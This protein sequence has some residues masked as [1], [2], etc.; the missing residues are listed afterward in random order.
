M[1]K[2]KIFGNIHNRAEYT[3]DILDNLTPADVKVLIKSCEEMRVAADF[4]RIFP[5][6]TTHRYQVFMDEVTYYDKLLDSFMTYCQDKSFMEGVQLVRNMTFFHF[7]DGFVSGR[8]NPLEV[9][10]RRRPRPEAPPTV[11]ADRR[12]ICGVSEVKE[13]LLKLPQLTRRSAVAEEAFGRA[14]KRDSILD[15]G[16]LSRILP[17][18]PSRNYPRLD[19][20]TDAE[21]RHRAAESRVATQP[22]LRMSQRLKV[23]LYGDFVLQALDANLLESIGK[24]VGNAK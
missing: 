23:L 10:R 6:A 5:T 4:T 1:D 13:R 17:R 22:L 11:V 24:R 19:Q 18:T 8:R 21:I 9:V 3:D 2:Q 20:L 7:P 15:S 12:T 16:N 14:E